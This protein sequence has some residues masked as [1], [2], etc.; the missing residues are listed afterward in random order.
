M[1]EKLIYGIQQ[2][3]IGVKN[4]DIAF[5]WYATKLGADALIFDDNNEATYMA[6]YMGGKPRKK[7]A[8]LGLNMQGGGGYEIWQYTNRK[9][10]KPENEFKVGDLGIQ[11]PFVKTNNITATYNRLKSSNENILSE[12]KKDPSGVKCFFLKDPFDNILKI[13][14]H[15]SFYQNKK[16]DVGGISGAAIGVSNID[17]SLKL[18][19]DVLG[20]DK[21]IFDKTDNFD[22]LEDLKNGSKRF[23]RIL[24][25]HSKKRVGGFSKFFGTSEIELIQCLEN[26]PTKI[27]KNRYWGDLGYIHLCFDVKNLKVLKEECKQKEV[28]FQVISQPSFNMGD[29]NGHWGYIED[30]DGTLI[31]FI[32]TNKVPLIKNLGIH[33]NLKNRNPKK[34]LPNWMIKAMALK[35]VKI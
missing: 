27:F 16:I 11:F 18:Y 3:G 23:R 31:E 13:K 24:L 7:R 5:K 10:S 6:K 35:R 21:V 19:K 15:T 17:V 26:E 33:I 4:A 22:D 8:L 1:K 30:N 32:E 14:E 12:I 28:P 9:P 25:T 29:A 2:I 20:Y 34:P